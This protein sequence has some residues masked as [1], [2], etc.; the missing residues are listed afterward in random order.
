LD[1]LVAAVDTADRTLAVARLER[2][3]VVEPCDVPGE[4]HRPVY[5]R[6][7][8][9]R[10]RHKLY[11]ALQSALD[12]GWHSHAWRLAPGLHSAYRLAGDWHRW[13][14]AYLAAIDAARAAG[15]DYAV[16]PLRVGLATAYAGAGE[17]DRAE[18]QLVG[19]LATAREFK[20]R[21]CELAAL[22]YLARL[23]VAR[24]RLE[25]AWTWLRAAEALAAG[26]SLD[27]GDRTEDRAAV[28]DQETRALLLLTRGELN[29]CRRGYDLADDDLDQALA[30]AMS[31][32]DGHACAVILC[33]QSQLRLDRGDPGGAAT[34]ARLAA[35]IAAA[36]RD[37]S[38]DPIIRRQLRRC[39]SSA[40]SGS[41]Q[42]G[43]AASS[44][45]ELVALGAHTSAIP[46]DNLTRAW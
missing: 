43:C 9:D 19:A 29:R 22:C 15:A 24:H 42:L 1:W 39:Q 44:E 26:S 5:A 28:A 7:W 17:L 11:A 40:R 35:A 3:T 23:A 21:R 8:L 36:G 37:A 32:G 4:L 33:A 34:G 20:N 12:H 13:A 38:A 31:L 6:G 2:L 30:A 46:H 14:P 16:G 41:P 45:P 18:H 25:A 10:E 27:S